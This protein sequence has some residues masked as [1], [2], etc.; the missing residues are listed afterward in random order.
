MP[1]KTEFFNPENLDF[2]LQEEEL[3]QISDRLL[4]EHA[5]PQ[6]EIRIICLSRDELRDMKREYFAED[7]Y[8]DVI[9]FPMDRS[10]DL[11]EGEIYISPKDI[12]RNARK[13]GTS[14][15]NECARI[16]IHGILHLLGY[17]DLT[18]EDKD[19]MTR[20]EDKYLGA[21]DF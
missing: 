20:M 18:A 7:A 1:G 19:E 12:A 15:R 8:T 6:S 16:V 4:A 21:L 11:L 14:Y 13:F 5:V 10:E 17:D 9:S 3:Q 2:P